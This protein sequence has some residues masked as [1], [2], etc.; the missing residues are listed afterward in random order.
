[1]TLLRS[2]ASKEYS[3]NWADAFGEKKSAK[4]TSK[5]SAK[6]KSGTA[7]KAKSTKA[8]KK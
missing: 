8:K 1:M 4:K 7:S 6:K 5:K 2:G 3:N